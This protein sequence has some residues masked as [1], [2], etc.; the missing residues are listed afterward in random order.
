[1]SP[2]AAE[3]GLYDKPPAKLIDFSISRASVFI[4]NQLL[5]SRQRASTQIG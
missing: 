4:A 1:M 5:F 2:E 3:R